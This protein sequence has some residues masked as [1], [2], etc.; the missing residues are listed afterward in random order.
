MVKSKLE[1]QDGL[2]RESEADGCNADIKFKITLKV[3][4]NH[5]IRLF[6]CR[7]CKPKFCSVGDD[8]VEVEV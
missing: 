1:V 7:S 8:S 5:A 4:T 3:G 6:V 2:D